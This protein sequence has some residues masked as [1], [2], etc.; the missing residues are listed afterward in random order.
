MRKTLGLKAL[1]YRG[2]AMG[3]GALVDIDFERMK[4]KRG[5]HARSFAIEALDRYSQRLHSFLMRRMH[6]AQDKDVDDLVQ[7]VWIRLL[8]ANKTEYVRDPLA[9]VLTIG[10]HVAERFGKRDRRT[11]EYVAVDSELAEFLSE[12]PAT[13][14]VDD[15]AERLSTERQLLNALAKLPALYQAV[16]IMF[17]RDGYKYAEIAE[18]LNISIHKVE[19]YLAEAKDAITAIDWELD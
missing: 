7:E 10:A 18:A 5:S 11:Q 6:R 12:N 13:Q 4:A 17:Y 9:Y 3:A 14:P 1:I 15:L 19:R 2:P 8:K 16:L